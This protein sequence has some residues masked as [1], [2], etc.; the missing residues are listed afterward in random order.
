[1]VEYNQVD[2]ASSE[3]ELEMDF[4]SSVSAVSGRTSPCTLDS[5]VSSQTLSSSESSWSP[6]GFEQMDYGGQNSE[7]AFCMEFQTALIN[8][9][10]QCL[11]NED[12]NCILNASAYLFH[13]CKAGFCKSIIDICPKL[14][15]YML[16]AVCDAGDS[17]A[18]VMHFLSGVLHYFSQSEECVDYVI[19]ETGM[20]LLAYFLNSPYE[21]VLYYSV[22][23]L[24]NI[25]LVRKF[26]RDVVRQTCV[27][28][29]LVRLLN[30]VNV[31]SDG[32]SPQSQSFFSDSSVNPKFLA[33]LCDCLHI[34]SYGHEGTKKIFLDENGTATL[35]GLI[36]SHR[37]EKLLWTATRLLRVLSAWTPAKLKI[38]SADPTLNFFTHCVR[39]GSF[40]LTANVLWT[41]RNLSDVAIDKVDFGAISIIVEELLVLLEQATGSTNLGNGSS[42]NDL[43][44]QFSVCRCILGILGNLT[45]GN[46]TVKGL[47]IR[48]NGIDL[49]VRVMLSML[50]EFGHHQQCLQ[51]DEVKRDGCPLC[52]SLSSLTLQ[53]D[54]PS[55]KPSSS[56]FRSSSSSSCSS[57]SN[58]SEEVSLIAHRISKH[59]NSNH[60]SGSLESLVSDTPSTGPPSCH[61]MISSCLTSGRTNIPQKVNRVFSSTLS[62]SYLS[63][64]KSIPSS[65][66]NTTLDLLEAGFRCLA[67]LTAGH[68]EEVN[69]AVYFFR[70]RQASRMLGDVV[71]YFFL[72]IICMYSSFPG[73]FDPVVSRL[74]V[75]RLCA[76]VDPLM[77]QTFQLIKAWATLVNN[78][79]SL[80]SS[81]ALID[82][83]LPTHTHSQVK[84]KSAYNVL[85]RHVVSHFRRGLRSLVDQLGRLTELIPTG[86][87]S[88]DFIAAYEL[89]HRL[90]EKVPLPISQ[91]S[92]KTPIPSARIEEGS[93]RETVYSSYS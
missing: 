76:N 41:L 27:I 74:K 16:P 89:V 61:A 87:R 18:D 15:S 34:L 56:S 37:Y 10:V 70:Q 62:S 90:V 33:V 45:C 47:C 11:A 64:S 86:D 85:P 63:S 21:S 40:R 32:R 58:T 48:R 84:K 67:H 57:S 79:C 60:S 35:L 68:N 73:K 77:N 59:T 14:L 4:D 7:I 65:P 30:F 42:P 46:K 88:K 54:S 66:V 23:A 31:F 9:A 75:S 50:T 24:H 43:R 38:I 19:N 20:E 91:D 51:R 26:A 6:L 72:P 5:G 83:G 13:I 1:M 8:Q 93:E 92:G 78:L 49:V 53:T 55:P 39:T 2:F 44:D 36:S 80:C 28:S 3:E 22:T 12:V 69:A 25:L 82:E 81:P 29:S 52:Y 71:N 17:G